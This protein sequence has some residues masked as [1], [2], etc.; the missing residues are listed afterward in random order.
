MRRCP[1]CGAEL[2]TLPLPSLPQRYASDA[3][4]QGPAFPAEQRR[5]DDTAP[6][7]EFL[8]AGA[9][10]AGLVML[11]AG[12]MLASMVVMAAGVFLMVGVT[13]FFA[14]V[15]PRAPI[16]RMIFSNDP[17][18]VSV[19]R[20]WFWSRLSFWHSRWHSPSE[21]GDGSERPDSNHDNANT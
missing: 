13:G 7:S 17:L 16:R 5:R 19:S 9:V 20:M 2:D 1:R 6:L 12:A 4:L 8:A 15:A 10:L 3:G 14:L 11:I 18:D 21:R